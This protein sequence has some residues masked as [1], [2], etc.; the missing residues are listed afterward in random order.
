MP[1]R[2]VHSERFMLNTLIV[3][4]VGIGFLRFLKWRMPVWYGW[5]GERFIS[6]KLRRLNKKHFRVLDDLMLPSNGNTCNT[7]IDHIAVSNFGIFCVETK[8]LSGWIFGSAKQRQWTQVL[9]R[10]KYRFFNPLRQNHAHVKAIEDLLGPERLRSPIVSLIAFPNADKL[11]ITGTDSVG[12][13]RDIIR[14]IKT[15]TEEVYTDAER[16]E[17]VAMLATANIVDR[18]ARRMHVKQVRRLKQ[19]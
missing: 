17:I 11:K 3:A 18:A 16:D 4:I 5:I 8:S 2:A 9:Y 7:Q 10:N 6:R 12:R 1:L 13:G 19:A 14:K 15:Y